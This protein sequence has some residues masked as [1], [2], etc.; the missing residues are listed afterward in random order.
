MKKHLFNVIFTRF[1]SN[2]KSLDP[3]K[4]EEF[5]NFDLESVS[6]GDLTATLD[7]IRNLTDHQKVKTVTKVHICMQKKL[8]R[9]SKFFFYFS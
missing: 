8:H 5:W 9:L 3:D 2:A 4:D 6:I 7:Y 1:L